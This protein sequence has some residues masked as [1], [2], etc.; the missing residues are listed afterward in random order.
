M[1]QYLPAAF[2]Q[3]SS[4]AFDQACLTLIAPCNCTFETQEPE[5]LESRSSE[6]DL[7]PPHHCNRNPFFLCS[8]SSI[9]CAV[10]T[11]EEAPAEPEYIDIDA[12][13]ADN[14]LACT[15][16][17]H[18]IMEYL[19]TSEVSLTDR[20]LPFRSDSHHISHQDSPPPQRW[21]AFHQ[22][23]P[24][25]AATVMLRRKPDRNLCWCSGNDGH[26]RPT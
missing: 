21:T 2:D 12:V 14:E 24:V 18:S 1:T 16:Y 6:I 4:L 22:P 13:D 11:E 8:I 7:S 17:V 19:F 9:R 5:L 3:V 25:H 26:W 10:Q 20:E 23:S 15:D